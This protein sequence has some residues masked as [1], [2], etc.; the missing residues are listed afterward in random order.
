[1]CGA[2]VAT[3]FEMTECFE[4]GGSNSK[5][6][7][8]LPFAPPPSPHLHCFAVFCL[9]LVAAYQEM[10]SALDMYS[11]TH[12]ICTA[13]LTERTQILHEQFVH[14]QYVYSVCNFAQNLHYYI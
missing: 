9:K 11:C 8:V 2:G 6:Y 1:M 14:L 12:T 10:F 5:S 3:Q 13:V 7:K 4:C